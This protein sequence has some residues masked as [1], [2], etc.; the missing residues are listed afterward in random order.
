MRWR[1]D[2]VL[3]GLGDAVPG[4]QRPLSSVIE[5]RIDFLFGQ[6]ATLASLQRGDDRCFL[7]LQL[8]VRFGHAAIVVQMRPAINAKEVGD[9]SDAPQILTTFAPLKFLLLEARVWRRPY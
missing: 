6:V 8:V 9:A 2:T 4:N 3:P 5:R 1:D 7:G